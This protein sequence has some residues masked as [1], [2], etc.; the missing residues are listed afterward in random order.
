MYVSCAVRKEKGY[1]NTKRIV[2]FLLR[3]PVS[4]SL[5]LVLYYCEG[6]GAAGPITIQLKAQKNFTPSLPP[7]LVV[8][9]PLLLPTK[10]LND[11]HASDTPPSLF[12]TAPTKERARRRA[13][14]KVFRCVGPQPACASKRLCAFL[15]FTF[16]PPETT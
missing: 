13:C 15:R 3:Q 9:I 6:A 2:R 11:S 8:L 10:S 4:L 5:S 1:F 12:F 14:D 16:S 7:L